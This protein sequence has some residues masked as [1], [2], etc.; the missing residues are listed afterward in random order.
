[1]ALLLVLDYTNEGFGFGLPFASDHEQ[2]LRDFVESEGISLGE[3]QFMGGS[4]DKRP[5]M[6]VAEMNW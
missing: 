4:H 1:M 3:A 6:V 2:V 5:F